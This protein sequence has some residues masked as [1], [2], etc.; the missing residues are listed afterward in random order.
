MR[1][2]ELTMNQLLEGLKKNYEFLNKEQKENFQWD[3][4]GVWRLTNGFANLETA[5][6]QYAELG[7]INTLIEDLRNAYKLYA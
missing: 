3:F 5:I 7:S 6:S 2:K 1:I 4:R